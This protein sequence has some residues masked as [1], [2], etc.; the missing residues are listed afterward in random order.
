MQISAY[1]YD[2]SG[3][4][5]KVELT[6]EVCEQLSNEKMLW[7]D[8]SSRDRETIQK[9][10][11]ILKLKNLP[12]SQL[13]SVSERAK[14]EKYENFYRFFII[15]VDTTEEDVLKPIP[16]DFIVGNNFVVT[17]H[18]GDVPYL[19]EFRELENGETRLGELDTEGFI[20]TFLDLH[21]VSYFRAIER[22]ERQ[23][24]KFDE[25]ILRT[26]I[27][28]KRFL[29]NM[30]KL[31][32]KVSKLRHWFVPQRDVFYALSRPD[33]R[34]T[35]ESEYV[36]DTFQNLNQHFESAIEA[37]ENT[38]ENGFKSFRFIHDSRDAQNE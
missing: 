37:I 25:L 38:R 7:V 24:D 11:S 33:F 27:D 22:I 23:V 21:L 1:L 4:D 14:L 30:I 8:V 6:E 31:R 17:I 36:A 3:A 15:S 28:N 26:S 5:E 13:M 34:P 18:E 12:L 35:A 29:E 20:T 19:I 10:G 2:A 9:V 32:R 16:I